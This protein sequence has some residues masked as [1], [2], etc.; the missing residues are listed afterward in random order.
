MDVFTFSSDIRDYIL[1]KQ[2]IRFRQEIVVKLWA[3]A[4]CLC[5]EFVLLTSDRDWEKEL[6]IRHDA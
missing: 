6:F 4:M 5:K 3:E 1:R 2:G